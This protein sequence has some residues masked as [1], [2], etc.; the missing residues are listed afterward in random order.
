MKRRQDKTGEKT[1][2]VRIVF[3]RK[4]RKFYRFFLFSSTLFDEKK[5]LKDKKTTTT[6]EHANTHQ[7]S[8]KLFPRINVYFILPNLLQALWPILPPIELNHQ[9]HQ[10]H[11]R[12]YSCHSEED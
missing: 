1:E 8:K 6:N 7:K 4:L 3:Y 5:K 11:Y 10:Y 2:D 12:Y 9:E